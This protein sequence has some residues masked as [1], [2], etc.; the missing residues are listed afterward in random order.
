[1][2]IVLPLYPFYSEI[3]LK[4]VILIGITCP[5]RQKDFS[6]YHNDIYGNSI[7]GSKGQT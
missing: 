7:E 3:V 6:D 2:F 1:M 4:M 5:P